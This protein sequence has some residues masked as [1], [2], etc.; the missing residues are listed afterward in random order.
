MALEHHGLDL[1]F[2]EGLVTGLADPLLEDGY[3][4]VPDRPGLGVDLN[5]DGIR[6]NLRAPS[7]LFEPTDEWNS[8]KL[9]FWR[10][11]AE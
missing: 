5:L 10:P 4:T 7:G 6:E 11:D 8:P 2:W 9:G 1:P 3:V